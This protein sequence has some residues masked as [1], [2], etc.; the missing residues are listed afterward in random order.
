[1]SRDKVLVAPSVLSADFSKL[2]EA[3]DIINKST[4]DWIHFDV[5]DGV[6]VP[7][8]S[9]GFPVLESV[10]RIKRKPVDVHLMIVNPEKF[11]R[12][13]AYYGSDHITVHYEACNHLHRAIYQIKDNGCK[14][15]VAI[16]PHV[17][18][19]NLSEI[20]KDVDI[21]NLMSVNPGFSGQKF[22]DNTFE[23]IKALKKLIQDKNTEATIIIDG[24]V[25][26]KNAPDLVKEGV[27][28]LVAGS[29]VFNS[30]DPLSTIE[31]LKTN[32]E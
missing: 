20:I 7:N 30:D 32:S 3:V 13:F 2:G 6:F 27:D 4:A 9:M 18:V 22:I 12:E 31:Q 1:M 15:G 23:K 21:V 14:A 24:G 26:L 25:N 11:I 10:S 5:M 8:I 17:R 28:V 29:T 19:D 16:N